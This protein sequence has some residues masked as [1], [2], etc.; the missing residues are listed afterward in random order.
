LCFVVLEWDLLPVKK[1]QLWVW[2]FAIGAFA[3]LLLPISLW[4]FWA[5]C[6]TVA[7]W[8]FKYPPNTLPIPFVPALLS[9][10]LGLVLMTW[11][12]VA[13]W[14]LVFHYE[15]LSLRQIALPW[16]VGLVGGTSIA[17]YWL[18]KFSASTGQ[19]DE[20]VFILPLV[21]TLVLEAMLLIRMCFNPA[22]TPLRSSVPDSPQNRRDIPCGDYI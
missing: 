7:S 5:V 2:R 22:R 12:I 13:L 4:Y 19:N 18:I 14:W 10:A 21:I 8:D 11:G 17:A 1:L 9:A 20:F 6:V 16:W 3:L 15:R